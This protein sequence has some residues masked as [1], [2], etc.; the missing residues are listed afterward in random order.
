[1]NTPDVP[2]IQ[3]LATWIQNQNQGFKMGVSESGSYVNVYHGKL[4]LGQITLIFPGQEQKQGFQYDWYS[5]HDTWPLIKLDPNSRYHRSIWP[6]ADP[7]SFTEILAIAVALRDELPVAWY[8]V[9]TRPRRV[10][11]LWRK[12]M[13]KFALITLLVFALGI[14]AEWVMLSNPTSGVVLN[15]EHQPITDNYKLYV[16]TSEGTTMEIR[17]PSRVWRDWLEPRVIQEK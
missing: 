2:I 5:E 9:F 12:P 10:Y 15:M 16:M 17:L 6:I 7:T 14:W 11:V 4:W 13:R 1:M 8:E 3:S